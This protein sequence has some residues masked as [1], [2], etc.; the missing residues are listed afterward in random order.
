MSSV[1]D[2][3]FPDVRQRVLALLFTSPDRSF[4]A[5]ELITLARSG[6]GAVQREL[7]SLLAAELVTVREQGNQKHY[8]ANAAS[9]VFAELRGLV[10]KTVGLADVL[11]AALAP[12][13]EQIAAAFVYGSVARHE[14]TAGS[15]VD[16]LV[17]SDSLG[18][19]ELFGALEAATQTLGRTMNPTLYTQDEL[20]RRRAQDNA[21]VT[22]VLAQPRIWLLGDEE[23]LA[24]GD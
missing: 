13:A 1:A 12:L 14:D 17:V 7:A 19:A 21:F 18:Y 20:A 6:K 22:R 11:R 24:H 23:V 10:L 9:P 3:L 5:N 2:A 4:Y 8:Q 16:V 15:D